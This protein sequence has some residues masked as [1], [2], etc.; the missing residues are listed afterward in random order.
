ML[1]SVLLLCQLYLTSAI[2]S[3]SEISADRIECEFDDTC[4]YGAVVDVQ[5][6]SL[7]SCQSAP[8][9]TNPIHVRKMLCRYCHQL[10]KES[11]YFCI[12]P[13]GD[14]T[15]PGVAR[16]YYVARCYAKPSTVCLGRREFLRM[17]H[18]V[19]PAG[20]SY[21]TTVT[22]SLFL[23]GLGADRFYLGMWREGLGKLFTFG[24]LGVWS[25]VDFVLVVVGYICP[26]GDPSYW[27]NAPPK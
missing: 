17:R 8:N 27:S 3:C 14:C 15:Q 16:S 13:S 26:S 12:P 18:C 21:G 5:C 6:K 4:H 11:E 9:N 1:F 24:G 10:T 2:P 22:L 25:V 23:G 19:H 20:K 7:V